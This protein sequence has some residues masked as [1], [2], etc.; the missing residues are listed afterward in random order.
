M[1]RYRPC[2][3]CRA[4]V[5]EFTGCEHWNPI[6]ESREARRR[7]ASKE[8]SQRRHVRKRAELERVRAASL[9]KLGYSE[10]RIAEWKAG[11]EP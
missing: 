7:L 4:L 8:R 1:E 2:G 5:P 10:E 11:Q 3:V 9:E 6:K